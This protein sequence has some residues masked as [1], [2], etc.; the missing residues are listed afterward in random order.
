M[1]KAVFAGYDSSGHYNLWVTDGT[2]AGTS[3][4]SAIGAY[5]AGLAQDIYP[6]FTALGGEILFEGIGSFLGTGSLPYLWVTNG[7]SGGTNENTSFEPVNPDFTVLGTK[8]IFEADFLTTGYLGLCVSDGTAAG[9]MELTA[10]GASSLGLFNIDSVPDF[11][12]LGSKALFVGFSTSGVD[13]WV[14]DGTS[15]G[16]S[17]VIVVGSFSTGLFFNGE[18]PDFTVIGNKALFEGVD[19]G[20]HLNLW[21]TDGTSAGTSEL[22]VAGTSSTGLFNDVSSPDFTVLGTKWLFE[23]LDTN[24]D[25]GLWASDGTSAGTSEL[26]AANAYKGGLFS[27]TVAGNAN[28]VFVD[29]DLTVL[30][31]KAVFAG[32]DA[33]GHSNLWVTDGTS[34]GT[35]EVTTS[36]AFAG[37][38]FN[39]TN[40]GTFAASVPDFTVLGTKALFEGYDTSGHIGL[41][42]TDGTSAG[43]SELAVAGANPNGLFLGVSNPDF[44]VF[45]SQLLFS[46]DDAAG[47]IGLWITNGTAAGTSE[48]V[49]AGASPSG[50]VP[51]DITVLTPVPSLTNTSDFYDNGNSDFLFQNSSGEG[52]IWELNGTSVLVAGS[53]GNPGPSWHVKG[54]G[55]FNGDDFSDVLWQ[56]DDGSVAIWE[57]NGANTIGAGVV[58]NPGPSWHAKGTGD[59]NGDGRADILWQ[60]D[61]GEAAIWAM[62]CTN[63]IATA[64]PGNPGPDW[65]IMGVGDYN[66][67]GKSDIL[68]Q[69]SSGAVAIWEMNGTSAIAGAIIANP[70]PTWHA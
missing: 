26:T 25:L 35:S 49:A 23:G 24:N 38:L 32:Y 56:N 63:V 5:S 51:T 65:H 46:G 44:T 3:E 2:P 31:N 21:A 14:T 60:N 40:A 12:V 64:S 18:N 4:L 41:W 33:S 16:T 11:T 8:V 68:W 30:V 62:N 22:T 42:V 20:D 69:N 58:G 53:I 10:A 1:T 43:T 67:D 29:P 70:G 52:D 9:T 54:T 66:N 50:L 48:I 13:L 61:S 7:T 37:G 17:E 57:M 47:H 27:N 6:D 28:V 15:A 39:Q 45:G 34:A 59:F 36:N 19:S 55:D